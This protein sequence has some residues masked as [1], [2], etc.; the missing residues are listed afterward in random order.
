MVKSGF[1]ILSLATF[2]LAF[3]EVKVAIG[4]WRIFVVTIEVANVANV[5]LSVPTTKKYL[6][7]N[8]FGQ[9]YFYWERSLG[10]ANI[11]YLSP[12]AYKYTIGLIDEYWQIKDALKQKLPANDFKKIDD[13]I[14]QAKKQIDEIEGIPPK[15]GGSV[16]REDFDNSLHFAFD[17]PYQ[18]NGTT[19][20]QSEKRAIKAYYVKNGKNNGLTILQKYRELTEMSDPALST[21]SKFISEWLKFPIIG[22]DIDKL[23]R[24]LKLIHPNISKTNKFN[25]SHKS[26]LDKMV[27][28]AGNGANKVTEFNTLITNI[29]IHKSKFDKLPPPNAN[30]NNTIKP[31][32]F[33]SSPLSV[34]N[35]FED[36][37]IR[38]IMDKHSTNYFEATPFNMR[39][40]NKNDLVDFFPVGTTQQ[41]VCVLLDEAIEKVKNDFWSGTLPT[42]AQIQ[43]KPRGAEA[44]DVIL[45]NGQTYRIGFTTNSEFY[46][47][48]YGS[49]FT[50]SNKYIIGQFYPKSDIERHNLL[51]LEILTLIP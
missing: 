50:F 47:G 8:G 29:S 44:Y 22:Q 15:K 19:F 24:I 40:A 18:I 34:V 35:P 20:T 21:G 23:E 41:Q 48:N 38:H 26:V 17:P 3:A 36:I 10:L 49:P 51:F 7:D 32:I 27:N 42:K 30:I 45:S 13:A 33:A 1:D 43:A 37:N 14:E 28:Y 4:F 11:V 16:D 39:G 2:P 46:I 12:F 6:V 25:N 5:V 9:F 31:A